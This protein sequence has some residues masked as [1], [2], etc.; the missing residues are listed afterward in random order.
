MLKQIFD[1]INKRAIPNSAKQ[2]LPR[3]II[4]VMLT[5]ILASFTTGLMVSCMPENGNLKDSSDNSYNDNSS[6]SANNAAGDSIS[7]ITTNPEN[8]P[9]V[10]GNVSNNLYDRNDDANYLVL[11]AETAAQRGE[12]DTAIEQYLRAAKLTDDISIAEK[13]LALADRYGNSAQAGAAAQRLLEL[14]PESEAA[15][16]VALLHQL[17]GNPNSGND[18][19]ASTFALAERYLLLEPGPIGARMLQLG[20]LLARDEA[21]TSHLELALQL[22]QKYPKLA[23]AHFVYGVELL[24]A[25][26]SKEA[27]YAADTAIRL[28][29]GWDKARVL[30][31][32]AAEAAGDPQRAQTILE[33]AIERTPSATPLRLEYALLLAKNDQLDAA[34]QQYLTILGYDNNQPQ[35]L[36]ALGRIAIDQGQPEVAKGYFEQLASNPQFQDRAVLWLGRLAESKGD[37]NQAVGWY[38]RVR[39]AESF[40]ALLN[41]GRILY[42][43]G[44]LEA[45]GDHF[46]RL[47]EAF[48]TE[49]STINM[50]QADLLSEYGSAETALEMLNTALAANPDDPDLLF[51]RGI[52]YEKLDNLEAAWSDWQRVIQQDPDNARAYN[53]WGYSLTLHTDRYT[54]AERLLNKAIELE[55]NSA[56]IQD[57]VGWLYFKLGETDKAITY[58]EQA[59]N[60][61]KHPEV[62]AHLGEV[63]WT[64]GRQSEAK[65]VWLEGLALP[66]DLTTITETL[67]R[68]N[69]EL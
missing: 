9:L 1:P 23:E 52:T 48:P 24:R 22:S 37:L 63:Y 4:A 21:T 44:K 32:Q 5:F 34:A 40:D 6:D 49:N 53:A 46:D 20:S 31:A 18:D 16:Q 43:Q 10:N 27:E 30:Q 56:A 58:L 36:A 64:T 29:P 33:Q 25:N 39:G 19:T 45:A 47:R 69:I 55:P 14:Q 12:F 67:T 51:S 68:L 11:L 66:D 41:V 13:S 62:A 35:A 7:D 15:I 3:H 8:T 59:W 61:L 54:E 38:I 2:T 26:E 17:R 50:R 65:Q 42:R 57:S 28:R 60:S